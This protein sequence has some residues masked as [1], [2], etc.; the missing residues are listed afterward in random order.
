[1]RSKY[2]RKHYLSRHP[3]CDTCL[4]ICYPASRL[5]TLMASS[6]ETKSSEMADQM[7][8]NANL[9]TTV[10]YPTYPPQPPQPA[11]VHLPPAYHHQSQTQLIQ[12]YDSRSSECCPSPPTPGSNDNVKAEAKLEDYYEIK[13]YLQVDFNGVFQEPTEAGSIPFVKTY[14]STIYYWTKRCM[15][16]FFSSLLGPILAFVFGIVFA[17]MDFIVIWLI[18]P[19]IRLVHVITRFSSSMYRPVTRMLLDPIFESFG[20]VY[21]VRNSGEFTER[22]YRLNVSGLTLGGVESHHQQTAQHQHQ[23]QHSS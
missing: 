20:Q 7:Q 14:N 13:P 2:L 5:G 19:I 9:Q 23:H 18:N 16:I 15:Y 22:S 17:L 3:E 1:M 6:P 8:Q 11:V 12:T 10:G 4:L 21:R